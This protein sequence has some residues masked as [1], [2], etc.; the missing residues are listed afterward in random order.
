M[1]TPAKHTHIINVRLKDARIA[2]GYTAKEVAKSIS[3][4][5][6]ALS[7]YELGKSTPP[8]EIF[9]KPFA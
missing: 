3:I 1:K 2:N 5:P 7:L 9:N 6:Q 4:S 8:P